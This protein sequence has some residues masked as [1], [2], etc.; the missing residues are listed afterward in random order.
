MEIEF[1]YKSSG[2]AVLP[3]EAEYAVLHG[4]VFVYNEGILEE[5]VSVGWRVPAYD[6]AYTEAR[7]LATV[8]H[9]VHYSTE[10]P[11]FA[12][13]DSAAGIITQIDN[14]VSGLRRCDELE[15]QIARLRVIIEEREATIDSLDPVIGAS[16]EWRD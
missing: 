2:T 8:L 15:E 14:M 7:D 3:G 16:G 12:L 13:C 11:N 1:Y 6:A 9:R 10:S 5:A 4:E